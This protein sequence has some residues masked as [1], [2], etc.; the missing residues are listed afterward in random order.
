MMWNE[1]CGVH[2]S[3]CRNQEGCVF[4]LKKRN[5]QIINQSWVKWSI[6]HH[7]H[8]FICLLEM[9]MCGANVSLSPRKV[10]RD[11]SWCSTTAEGQQTHCA[12]GAGETQRQQTNHSERS[13]WM[14]NHHNSLCLMSKLRLGFALFW[15]FNIPNKAHFV[16]CLFRK[17]T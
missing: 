2:I 4:R 16:F 13:C 14:K 11:T 9:Q 1:C 8:F 17:I 6:L 7:H 10:M 15:G 5:I 12:G 3:N